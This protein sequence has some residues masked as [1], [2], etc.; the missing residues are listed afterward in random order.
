MHTIRIAAVGYVLP[1]HDHHGKGVKLDPLADVIRRVAREEKPDFIC[2]PEICACAGPLEQGMRHAPALEPFVAAVGKLAREV[3]AALIVPT[4]E[5]AD[6][7][8]YN[9]VPIVDASGKLVLVYRKNYLTIDDGE[10]EAGITPGVEVPVAECG[11]VRVGAAV[12]Y[13]AHFLQ[14]AAE[15]ERGRARVVFWPSMFW[16]GRLLELW[17]LRFGFYVVVAFQ[18]E[19]AIIDMSGR[20]LARGGTD[21]FQV[22]GGRLPPWAVAEINTDRELF[23]LNSV[24]DKFPA[25]RQK[26]GPGGVEIEVLQ[27]EASCLLASRRS[28]VTVEQIAREFR[29]ET[30][31]DYLARS[32]RLR[33]KALRTHGRK[34]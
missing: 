15:L 33:D 16:G 1:A 24:Q 23:H 5:R 6:K 9:S 32:V 28:D 34:D 20:Y 26:Y 21:T 11:G 2:F 29:L 25:L 14:V 8:I 3:R 18:N 7:Q 31:R 22:R 4:L 30:M 17:A 12:C 13:D 10:I 19:S 27:P